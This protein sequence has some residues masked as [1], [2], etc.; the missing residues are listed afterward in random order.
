MD[1][2]IKEAIEK[3][4]CCGCV[5]GSD[6]KC[7]KQDN[8]GVGC[9]KH[10]A[11]TLVSGIGKIFLGLPKGFNRLGFQNDM[12]TQV[13]TTLEE[14]QE[15]YAYDKFNVPVWK[16]FDEGV[17]LVRGYLPRLNQGF[18]H[19]ILNVDIDCIGGLELNK[20]DIDGMD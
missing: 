16:Y 8:V 5:C 14:Q 6:T 7:Y 15:V 2:K 1:N 12:K 18:V 17:V 10:V 4:Q 11:G 9:A 13:F 20:A 3:Y 19:I